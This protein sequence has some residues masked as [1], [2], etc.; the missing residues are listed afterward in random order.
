MTDE[1]LLRLKE[2]YYRE[3]CKALIKAQRMK[4]ELEVFESILK[5]QSEPSELETLRME[6]AILK[7]KLEEIKSIISS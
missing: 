6:N 7:K 1:E 2:E 3:K 4:C 5:A